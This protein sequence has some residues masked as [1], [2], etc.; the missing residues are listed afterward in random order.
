[1]AGLDESDKLAKFLKEKEM[2]IPHIEGT[3]FTIDRAHDDKKVVYRCFR[4]GKELVPPYV[5]CVATRLSAPVE[6][7][8]IPTEVQQLIFNA[9]SRPTSSK[10]VYETIIAALPDRVISLHLK[11]S[12][13]VIPTVLICDHEEARL[14]NVTVEQKTETSMPTKIILYGMVFIKNESGQ[15]QQKLVVEEVPVT[16]GMQATYRQCAIRQKLSYFTS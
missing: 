9:T 15:R 2:L 7:I 16:P 8:D 10:A 5:S 6:R 12:G 1:M 14:L 3:L 13:A 4:K 11:K